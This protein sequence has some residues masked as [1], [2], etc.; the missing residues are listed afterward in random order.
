MV[1]G[2][3]GVKYVMYLVLIWLQSFTAPKCLFGLLYALFDCFVLIILILQFC[4][5]N[6]G[7]LAELETQDEDTGINDYLDRGSYYWIGL[8]RD[9]G[10]DGK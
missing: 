3:T 9:V 4:L 1:R 2:Q 7:Y 10:K 6:K 8:R 5:D